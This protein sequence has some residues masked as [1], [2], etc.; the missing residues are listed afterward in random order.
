[1]IQK[2][3]HY[4]MIA[5]S[6]FMLVAPMAVPA[7]AAA[8]SCKT[9]TANQIADGATGASGNTVDCQSQTNTGS[10][11][12]KLARQIV[13]IFSIVVGAVAVIMIIYGGFRYITS[14]GDSNRVG[15]A[16]NTLIY[17]IIG[18]VI[19][20]LAQIIVRFVLSTSTNAIT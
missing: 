18:L 20:A 1:M 11:I 13:D 6:A 16:K 7:V 3:K 17:A 9:H 8:A 2:L 10:S 14:G 4:L 19:V 5:A 12:T 15:S